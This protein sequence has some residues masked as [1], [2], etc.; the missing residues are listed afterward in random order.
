MTLYIIPHSPQSSNLE[1]P[2]SPGGHV[3]GSS[4]TSMDNKAQPLVELPL[5]TYGS[6]RKWDDPVIPPP[7]N[8]ATPT[9]LGFQ[10]QLE[11]EMSQLEEA[12]DQ[13]VIL[14]LQPAMIGDDEAARR[15][16]GGKGGRHFRHNWA[17]LSF[18]PDER[19]KAIPN[20][21]GLYLGANRLFYPSPSTAQAILHQRNWKR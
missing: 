20:T 15:P 1:E 10:A 4:L 13:E 7:V 17:H 21:W 5:G 2:F 12:L 16:I 8:L 3:P 19:K 6:K 18:A 14:A 11:S 9:T